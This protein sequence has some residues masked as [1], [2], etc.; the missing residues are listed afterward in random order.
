MGLLGYGLVTAWLPFA[1]PEIWFLLAAVVA[2]GLFSGIA[3]SA[4]YQA[5]D[6]CDAPSSCHDCCTPPPRLTAC[7]LRILPASSPPPSADPALSCTALPSQLVARFANKNVI[8]LGLGCSASGPL[9]LAMQLALGMGASPT[10]E[11]QVGGRAEAAV[12]DWHS[13]LHWSLPGRLQVEPHVPRCDPPLPS[14][15]DLA[16]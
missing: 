6:P 8:A 16:V 10:T 5:C 14:T 3:F 13:A 12:G 15:T 7:L 4:S 9:V 11:Q 1:P 2:L